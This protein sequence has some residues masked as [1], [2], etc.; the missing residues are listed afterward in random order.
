MAAVVQAVLGDAEARGDAPADPEAGHLR[1]PALF[2]TTLMRALGAQSDGVYLR[3]QT[4][5]MGQ[6]LFTPAT[7][8]NYYPPGYQL[9]GTSR[10]APE[11]YIQNAATA[12][13]RTNFLNQLIY[14]GGA[15]A[16]PT[17]SGSTGTSVDLSALAGSPPLSPDQLVDA[18]STRLMHGSLSSAAHDAIVVAVNAAPATDPLGQVR[19][20]TYLIASSAQFQ[21]EH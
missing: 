12:L 3:G 11:F 13:N 7:V 2:I 15:A 14:N 17:V 1:E 10:L 19:A 9:P 16:D 20:A 4:N 8:F 5:G 6:P 21:V 18:L